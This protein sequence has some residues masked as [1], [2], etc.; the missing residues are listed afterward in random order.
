MVD[1]VTVTVGSLVVGALSMAAEA[2]L[3]GAV[4]EAV[5]DGY[6]AL[7]KKV[8]DWAPSDVEELEKTPNSATRRAVIAE[9]I[10]A[11]SEDDRTS[12]CLLAEALVAKLKERSSGIGLDIGR[13]TALEVGLGNITVTSGTGARVEEANVATFKTGNILVGDRSGK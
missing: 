4:G 6:K 12:L 1:P 9:I 2:V 5:K 11:Q 10:D 8:S 13:L 7:K 3:K